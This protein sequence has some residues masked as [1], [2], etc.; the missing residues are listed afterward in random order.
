MP[1]W[2]DRWIEKERERREARRFTASGV[3]H[4]AEANLEAGVL[5]AEGFIGR[6]TRPL[7]RIIR[8]DEAAFRDLGLD[9]NLVAEHLERLV[10]RGSAGL[11][12]PISVEGRYLVRV[13]ETRGS[14]PCPW[15]DGLFRKRSVT[16]R[17][18]DET[19]QAQ[20]TELLFSDLSLHLL[21][22]HHFLQGQGSPFR[23]DPRALAEV[24]G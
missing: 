9:W 20:G 1:A 13:A 21:R 14:F 12:E 15:E 4:R 8:E 18:L 10:E 6:D 3:L 24:L 22:E 16:V 5:T 7:L 23:L 2:F 19:G 17:R 11:G